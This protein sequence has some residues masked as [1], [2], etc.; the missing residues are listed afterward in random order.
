[1]A[2]Q[3]QDNWWAQDQTVTP[4]S[5][6][7]QAPPAVIPGP[8]KVPDAAEAERLEMARRDQARQDALAP[9]QV[10]AAELEVKKKQRE[11]QGAVGKPMRQGDANQLDEQVSAYSYLKNALNSFQDDYAGNTITGELEN[12][13]QAA[14]GTGTPG[15]RD[16][17]SNF[18]TADNLIRNQLFGASLTA[19]EKAAYDRT[20]ITPAMTPAEVRR[21]LERRV[22]I[23]RDALSR[24]VGRLRAAGFN[25]Q[26]IEAATGEF[27]P[28]FT[29]SPTGGP[30]QQDADGIAFADEEKPV[31]GYRFTPEQEA[32]VERAIRDGDLGQTVALVQRFNGGRPVDTAGLKSAIDAV[33]RDPNA[34]ISL[35]YA[36]ADA[37][38]QAA[39]DKERFGDYLP[40]AIEERKGAGID[41]AVRG[42]ADIVPFMDEIAA[43][44]DTLFSGGTYADNLRRQRAIDEADTRVNAGPRFAGQLAGALLPVGRFAGFGRVPGAARGA[45]SYGA[46]GAVLGGLYSAGKAD[47]SPDSSLGQAALQRAGAVP[48]GALAGGALGAGF[49][50]LGN[51]L[52]RP[53]RGGGPPPPGGEE[54]VEIAR[55]AA[56]EGVPLSRPI[57]D[58]SRRNAMAYLES[59]IGGG[60]TVRGALERTREGIETRASGLGAG[61]TAQEEYA[62]GSAIQKGAREYIS[63]SKGLKDRLYNR[64]AQIAGDAKVVPTAAVKKLDD[65]IAQLSRNPNQ[66]AAEINFLQKYRADLVDADGNPMPKTVQEIRD[67]R[68]NLRGVVGQNNLTASQAE[69]RVIGA[70]DA[71]KADIQRD[72]SATNPAAVRA[73]DRA[74][75]FYRERQAEIKGVVQ[76]V[77]GRSRNEADQISPE[78]AWQNIKTMAGPR[79]D[80]SA[81]QRMWNKLDPETQT[82]AAATLAE[83]FGKRAVDEPF[84]PERFITAT[85]GLS[86]SARKTIFGPEGARSIENLRMLSRAYSQTAKSLNNSRSGVVINWANELKS[87]VTRGG[88]G[89]LAGSAVAGP[90]GGAVGGAVG[91]GTGQIARYLTARAL[92]SPDMSRW[93]AQAPRQTTPRAIASH[94]AKLS[95]AVA[96]RD[97]AI[98]QDA[99][100]L[101]RY[102]QQ[103]IS[104]TPSRAAAADEE[105]Q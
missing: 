78:R 72:L 23:A 62:I 56:E 37:E 44:G 89:G 59:S 58:P 86:R 102:L 88:I 70:L 1:M 75:K 36:A 30:T 2:W 66:N 40:Q 26:E 24:R 65:E 11:L 73:Y 84:S 87:I 31:I 95:S 28:D 104:Q 82:D 5:G 16:W 83:S 101:Q 10:Q 12:W 8:P 19:N 25:P 46:E 39:A 32:Q 29:P 45:L 51:Y 48:T 42:A 47:P 35:N 63:R 53:P 7:R 27:A 92:M 34:R 33:R 13:A 41:A 71:A 6:R 15:Q 20:S 64:A 96:R 55:A 76:R 4:Q 69:S 50:A 52:S 85:N 49:G 38:A 79:G 97:P 93:L 90:V 3:D 57:V 91:V 22:E 67:M 14:I 100:G 17:W 61:G 18:R 81:L 77:L 105:K 60:N 74:D 54:A 98:A 94:V 68:T 43:A 9:L 103:A 80:S 99:L 21:N